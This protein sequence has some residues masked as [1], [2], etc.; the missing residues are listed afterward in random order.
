MKIALIGSAPSSVR[1]GPYKDASYGVYA[2]GRPQLE[3]SQFPFVEEEWECWGCSPGVYGVAERLTRWFE[4]HRWEPGQPWFSPEYVQFLTQFKGKVYTGEVVPE[5]ANSTRLPREMVVDKFSPFFL[6]SSLAFM[7]ALAIIEIEA[8]R[9]VGDRPEGTVDTIGFW[10]VDMAATEEYGYQ[11][12]GCQFFMLEANRRGIEVVLPPESD[13]HRPMPMYG[14]G[15]WS[16]A[17]IKSM[18][19]K[20]ELEG[21]LSGAQQTL[22][23]AQNESFFLKGALENQDYMMKTWVLNEASDMVAVGKDGKQLLYMR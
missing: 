15:E 1:L 8:D 14:I 12:A 3:P 7:A 16:A 13:L 10:G 18:A 6:T 5:I 4:L 11:R 19:R 21:R 9:L 20:R 17:Y 2:A 23:H 22:Q